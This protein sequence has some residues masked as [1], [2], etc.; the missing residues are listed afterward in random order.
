MSSNQHR[1]HSYHCFRALVRV[2]TAFFAAELAFLVIDFVTARATSRALLYSLV[3]CNATMDF[4]CVH[5]HTCQCRQRVAR[6]TKPTPAIP[7]AIT[8]HSYSLLHFPPP[9]PLFLS[10]SL[11]LSLSLSLIHSLSHRS[12]FL[13][14]FACSFHLPPPHAVPSFPLPPSSS[15][16][17]SLPFSFTPY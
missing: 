2:H 11:S 7:A 17:P 4:P 8:S 10:F 6:L 14:S 13:H 12:S 9:S 16:R 3:H 5:R 15:S 1:S